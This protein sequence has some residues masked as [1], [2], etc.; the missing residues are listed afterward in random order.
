MCFSQA[1]ENYVISV[2]VMMK[3]YEALNFGILIRNESKK[4]K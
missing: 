3:I 4:K 1:N 2:I